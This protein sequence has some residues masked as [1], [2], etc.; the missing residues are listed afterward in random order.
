MTESERVER[1]ILKTNTIDGT[2][3][4]FV[5]PRDN[6]RTTCLSL[7]QAQEIR[8]EWDWHKERW[9]KIGVDN[10][11]TFKDHSKVIYDWYSGKWYASR[12]CEEDILVSSLYSSPRDAER[13]KNFLDEEGWTSFN[14]TREKQYRGEVTNKYNG[15]L[16]TRDGYL[17]RDNDGNKYGYY[18]T[19]DEAR[20]KKNELV[21]EGV[22]L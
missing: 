20:E 22:L 13:V 10:E 3:Y 5:D 2:Y 1:C 16:P 15:I 14:L 18:H 9:S 11:V 21:K 12:E 4:Q 17:I 8:R 6:T 7:E 19:L